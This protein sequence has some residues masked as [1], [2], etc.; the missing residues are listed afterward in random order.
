[1][2]AAVVAGLVA[3]LV[4]AGFVVVPG[5]A[6][7]GSEHWAGLVMMRPGPSGLPCAV[8]VAV[9][10]VFVGASFVPRDDQVGRLGGA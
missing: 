1:M 3:E 6:G 7:S 9:V 4:V 2:W 8:A 10:A 5:V